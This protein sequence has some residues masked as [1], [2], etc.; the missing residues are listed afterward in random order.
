VGSTKSSLIFALTI[1]ATAAWAQDTRTVTEPAI[2]KTCAVLTAQLTAIDGNKT[3]ADADEGR[4]D[5]ARIQKAL[6]TCPRGQAVEFRPEGAHNA[7][8]AGPLDLRAGVTLRVDAKAIMFGSRDAKLYEIRPGSCGI[9][10]ASG[11]GCRALINGN[12]VAG[13]AI[14]GDG[15]IDGRG[16]AKVLGKDV[17]WWELA[18]QARKGGNQNC[19]RLAVLDRCDNFTLYR[20]TLKNSPNFHVAYRNGNGFTA[21]GVII[22]TP[23]TARNTDGIDPGP[24]SNVT[25]THCYI[26]TG[27][28]NV[29]IKAGG[30]CDHMT[31]SHNHFYT[32][33]GM[34]IGSETDGGADTIRVT[35]LS[36][37]GADNGLRIKSNSG[38]GRKVTDVV[39][40][41][42]CIRNT[43]Y[44]IFMDSNYANFGKNGDKLPWFTGIVL[45]NVR[46]LDGGRL[47]LQGFDEKHRLG[48]T[49]DNVQFDSP[50]D[51]RVAAEF[52]D[53]IYGPGP[54]NLKLSGESV[55]IVGSPGT[56]TP[57]TCS[58][59]FVPLPER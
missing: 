11:R 55:E 6:D 39:Y 52:A 46:V 14:M 9:V 20:I 37:D 29:A 7:F 51:I 15:I 54:M 28:D 10:D 47:T 40:E 33:H 44:P 25:I 59:K 43:K 49:F 13:A 45:R 34:S 21:W 42:V 48:M 16:W 30:K 18:E 19:P 53:F 36:I 8:L 17:S 1:A 38:R 50:K 27:D 3:V 41:D 35:D 22:D 23:K 12:G 5:T 32:G 58:D 24:A 4:L 31:I 26:H 56:G 2:P 57:N